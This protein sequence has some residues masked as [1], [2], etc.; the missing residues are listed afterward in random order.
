MLGLFALFAYLWR[1]RGSAPFA[2]YILGQ[3]LLWSGL[4]RL[5]IEFVRRNP[6]WLIGL[7]TAQWMSLGSMVVGVMLIRRVPTT[8][9][10]HSSRSAV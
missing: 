3:Y 2:G 8:S 4:L 1:H 5:L 7:T 9:N 6:A 10:Q